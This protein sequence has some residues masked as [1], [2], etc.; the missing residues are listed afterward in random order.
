MMRERST[1]IVGADDTL[2]Y[3]VL[4]HAK[5]DGV[6]STK[7]ILKDP[8]DPIDKQKKD[9]LRHRINQLKT[10]YGMDIFPHYRF[11]KKQTD[12]NLY[13]LVQEKITFESG[14][15]VFGHIPAELSPDL[16]K[17]IGQLAQDLRKSFLLATAEEKPERDPNQNAVLD[18]FG[19]ENLIIS[20]EQK[21]LYLDSGLKGTDY[22]KM[23][24]RRIITLLARIIVLD[25]VS[26]R[27]FDEIVQDESFRYI[28]PYLSEAERVGMRGTASIEEVKESLMRI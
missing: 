19:R 1:R 22:S 23:S 18:L 10:Q 26:G 16:K 3:R 12:Q 24:D 25:I 14:R 6:E 13:I 4:A 7:T 11:L 28:E 5:I 15:D 20:D 21:L 8:I 17:R 27:A 9:E 2:E